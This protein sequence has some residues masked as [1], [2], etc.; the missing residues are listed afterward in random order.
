M[1]IKLQNCFN[2]SKS[3]LLCKIK[4]LFY[5]YIWFQCILPFY[6]IATLMTNPSI[7]WKLQYSCRLPL[8]SY[9]CL[10]FLGLVTDLNACLMKFYFL[11]LRYLILRIP[12]KLFQEC[13]TLSKKSYDQTNTGCNAFLASCNKSITSWQNI[14]L[15]FIFPTI[16]FYIFCIF[17]CAA[18]IL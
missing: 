8:S 11:M 10:F 9:L 2:R 4:W 7:C 18:F 16:K 17:H 12:G 13:F 14:L 1:Q 5:E 15:G 3:H 6:F